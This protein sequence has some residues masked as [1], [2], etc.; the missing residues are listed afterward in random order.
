MRKELIALIALSGFIISQNATAI[1]LLGVFAGNDG[2]NADGS[3]QIEAL[4]ASQSPP[5]LI[6][7]VDQYAR[8]DWIDDADPFTPG[9]QLLNPQSDNGLVITGTTFKTGNDQTE[10]IEGSWDTGAI[11]LDYLTIKFDGYVA[12]YDLMGETSGNFDVAFLCSQ[13]TA[14]AAAGQTY[15][16]SHAAGYTVIPVPAAAWLFGSGLLGLVGVAR[17][18]KVAA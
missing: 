6:P 7:D 15:A 12:V 2:I 4:L 11:M 1:T 14:C 3:T 8:V 9:K 13:N 10:V 18:R 17:R 16:L 5:I